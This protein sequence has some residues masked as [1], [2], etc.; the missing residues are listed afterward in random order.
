MY[1]STDMLPA[2]IV[3]TIQFWVTVLL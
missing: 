2:R 1:E 3:T